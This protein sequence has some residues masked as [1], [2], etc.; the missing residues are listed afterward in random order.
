MGGENCNTEICWAASE[1]A[2]CILFSNTCYK[3]QYGWLPVIAG[4]WRLGSRIINPSLHSAFAESSGF[5]P[6]TCATMWKQDKEGD[7]LQVQYFRSALVGRQG[8]YWEHQVA[9]KRAWS[10]ETVWAEGQQ[11]NVLSMF[12]WLW[13]WCNL[14][15]CTFELGQAAGMKRHNPQRWASGI[16]KLSLF[17]EII[18]F[19]RAEEPPQGKGMFGSLQTPL[20]YGFFGSALAK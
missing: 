18:Q 1:L 10:L 3:P 8:G 17:K 4:A 7:K 14:P 16:M 2:H 19:W 15:I 11:V 20:P 9:R 6:Q 12:R 5:Q 13:V